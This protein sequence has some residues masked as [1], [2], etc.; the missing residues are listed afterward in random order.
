MR[1]SKRRRERASGAEEL[2]VAPIMNLFVAIVQLLLL[3]AVFVSVTSIELGAPVQSELPQ[4]ADDFALVLRITGRDWWVEARG[5]SPLQV[6][7]GDADTLLRALD[8]LHAAHP[9][10][11]SVLVACEASVAYAEVVRVLDLAALA[12]FADCALV[13]APGAAAAGGSAASGSSGSVSPASV[14]PASG[15]RASV[16]QVGESS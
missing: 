13:G 8:T 7:K 12:G 1:R 16:S 15:S 10:H 4:R 2:Q 3:S 11:T 6:A 14:S 9:Q 5:T